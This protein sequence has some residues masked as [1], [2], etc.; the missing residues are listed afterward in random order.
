M[1]TPS[2]EHYSL[3]VGGVGRRV[4]ITLRECA[5]FAGLTPEEICLGVSPSA[6]HRML[7]SRYLL[8]LWRGA[9]TVRNL[10]AADIRHSVRMGDPDRAA[11]AFIVLRQFLADFPQARF[12]PA[13][14][15]SRTLRARPRGEAR[16]R[17]SRNLSRRRIGV[18]PALANIFLETISPDDMETRETVICQPLAWRES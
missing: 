9:R 1:V 13:S 3:G 17:R 4:V 16:R 18:R 14:A 2:L 5:S 8:D 15:S 6:K 12:E 11:D 7:Q 10:I